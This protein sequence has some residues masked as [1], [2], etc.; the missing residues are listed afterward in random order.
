MKTTKKTEKRIRKLKAKRQASGKPSPALRQ[1]PM[2]GALIPR[3]LQTEPNTT[4]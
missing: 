4:S 3:C 1:Y 2:P